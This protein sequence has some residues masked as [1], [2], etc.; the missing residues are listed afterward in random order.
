MKASQLVSLLFTVAL[1][2]LY[3]VTN[4]QIISDFTLNNTS[5]DKPFM[6]SSLKEPIG[7]VVIFVSNDCPFVE[8]YNNRIDQIHNQF[9]DQGIKLVLINSNSSDQ[10][11]GQE[12]AE[13]EYSYPY[14]IDPDQKISKLFEARKT[15]EAFLLRPNGSQYHVVYRGAID[16]N[17]QNEDDVDFSYLVNAIDRMLQK[18]AIGR[19]SRHPIG[20]MIKS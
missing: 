16:D 20:C 4:A 7:I 19:I 11:S 17:P 3:L 9:N 18:K 5:N 14:L 10:K 8:S 15:P 6:L 1:F 13:Q 12:I 2:H